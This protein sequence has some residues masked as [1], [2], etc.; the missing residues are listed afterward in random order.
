MNTTKKTFLFL[1]LVLIIYL[2]FNLFVVIVDPNY[3]YNLVNIKGFNE[4]KLYYSSRTHVHILDKLY[5]VL[6]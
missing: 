4:K 6:K 3:E 2:L 1:I 5:I